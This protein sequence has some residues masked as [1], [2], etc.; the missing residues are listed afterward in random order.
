VTGSVRAWLK[1]E[2]LAV[3]VLSV[4]LYWI[5]GASWRTFALLFLAPDLSIAA[6]LG[7]PRLGARVYNLIHTYAVPLA[8]LAVLLMLEMGR[9]APLV[10]VWTA[11]IGFDRALGF[12]L[13]YPGAFGAT[14]LGPA[15]R[16]RSE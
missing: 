11:H 9:P 4:T 15:G 5:L 10:L 13:K 16:R 1:A 8:L 6:Y 14:H 3:L 7:G 2:G 12:G